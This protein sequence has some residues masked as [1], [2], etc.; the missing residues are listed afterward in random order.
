MSRHTTRAFT[1]ASIQWRIRHPGMEGHRTVCW[2]KMRLW[3]LV[4]LSEELVLWLWFGFESG[5][6]GVWDR[7]REQTICVQAYGYVGVVVSPL[8]SCIEVVREVWQTVVAAIFNF[9]GSSHLRWQNSNNSKLCDK[10][11]AR[12]SPMLQ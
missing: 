5:G 6:E 1:I 4:R 7:R 9:V 11:Q 10:L 3:S 2:V 8:Q 12:L